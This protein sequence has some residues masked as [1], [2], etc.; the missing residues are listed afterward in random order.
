MQNTLQGK[1]TIVISGANLFSG[2]TLSI[3]QDCLNYLNDNLTD[4]YR[5]IALVHSASYYSGCYN[6]EFREFTH[7]RDSYFQRLKLEYGYYKKLSKEIAPYLWFSLNDMSSSV[8]AERRAVYCH[9]PTPF[10]KLDFKDLRM[11][12]SVF[13]FTLFY[14]Y[15]YKINIHRNNYVVVQQNWIRDGFVRLFKLDAKKIIV[16]PP[17]VGNLSIHESDPGEFQK[18]GSETIFCFPAL[19]RP[20]KNIELIAAAT[21]LLVQSGVTNFKV[22]LT[23]DGTENEYAKEIFSKYGQLRQLG[24][25]GK[26]KR[27]DVFKLYAAS[28]CLIFPSTLET[29]GLPIT[30]FK[31]FNK[32][33][34]AANLPY[35]KE[36]VSDYDKVCFFD[37]GEVQQLVEAM[38]GVIHNSIT[39]DLTSKMKISLPFANGWKELFDLLLS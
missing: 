8:T 9:N 27:E 13:F 6:I 30:E 25:L 2:G 3:M 4:N 22:L 16:S 5:I 34:L 31:L 20:F 10:K 26:L 23:I 28:D 36:T 35:A 24:F 12:P 33:I 29:W 14:K 32:P 38:K 17:K 7:A 21:Q 1:K 18:H 19:A 15:L 37:P 11:E 39:F